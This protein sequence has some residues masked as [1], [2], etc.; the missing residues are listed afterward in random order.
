MV[1]GARLGTGEGFLGLLSS[2]PPA[3]S[4]WLPPTAGFC[5]PQG[6]L[7]FSASTLSEGKRPSL[8]TA[9]LTNPD[10]NRVASLGVGEEEQLMPGR[11]QS[12]RPPAASPGL[13]HE[14]PQPCHPSMGAC[15]CLRDTPTNQ[16]LAWPPGRL[17]ARAASCDAGKERLERNPEGQKAALST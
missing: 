17:R 1:T 5:A 10:S 14:L 11:D 3:S 16:A 13:R 6:A 15:L 2:F 12:S 7:K 4:A 9:S 8:F